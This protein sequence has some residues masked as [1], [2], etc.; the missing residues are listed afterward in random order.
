MMV[1]AHG[2]CIKRNIYKALMI[3]RIM[4]DQQ[5]SIRFGIKYGSVYPDIKYVSILDHRTK[6]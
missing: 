4:M 6:A 1:I 3:Y 2:A 5:L